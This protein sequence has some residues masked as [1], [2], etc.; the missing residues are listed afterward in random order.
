MPMMLRACQRYQFS[1][2]RKLLAAPMQQGKLI[3]EHDLSVI[4]RPGR[5]QHATILTKL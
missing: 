5:D 4:S 3:A 2:T 1:A